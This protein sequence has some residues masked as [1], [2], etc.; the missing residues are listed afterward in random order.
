MKQPA[1]RSPE[2]VPVAQ[3]SQ[4]APDCCHSAL[5]AHEWIEWVKSSSSTNTNLGELARNFGMLVKEQLACT[6]SKPEALKS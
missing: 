6:D 4:T 2:L 1:S 3:K 5:E